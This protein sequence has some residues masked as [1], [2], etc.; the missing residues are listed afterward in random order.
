MT[1]RL[2]YKKNLWNIKIWVGIVSDNQLKKPTKTLLKAKLFNKQVKWS[3]KY[4][5]GKKIRERSKESFINAQAL[6]L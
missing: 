3:G 1:A 2:F 6:K 5:F 4:W